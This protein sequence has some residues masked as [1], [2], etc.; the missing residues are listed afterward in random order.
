MS[1]WCDDAVDGL[2]K[3]G[4]YRGAAVISDQAIKLVNDLIDAKMSA[5]EFVDAG[6]GKNTARQINDS[7]RRDM[8]LWISEESD[9][10]AV[11]FL[12]CMVEEFRR[13]VNRELF[14]GLEAFEGHLA[15]YPA[16]GFY[17]KH[18]DTFR[19]DDARQVSFILYLN[20]GWKVEDGG[21]L[22]L[23]TDNERFEDIEPA[24][25]TIVI[26]RSRDFAHEVLASNK[27]RR[28]FTG[29]FKTRSLQP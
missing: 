17:K 4:W 28:S 26:F 13:A 8:T 29:W 25:G 12:M 18:V 23:Y 11:S 3:S 1:Q 24:A 15:V 20:E 5:G 7:I 19:N 22:R 9:D 27:E 6:I 21:C 14:A 2:A 16:G 10:P